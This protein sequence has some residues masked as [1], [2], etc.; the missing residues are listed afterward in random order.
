MNRRKS[1]KKHTSSTYRDWTT[2]T[3]E[4]IINERTK[5]TVSWC[6]CEHTHRAIYKWISKMWDKRATRSK[7]KWATHTPPILSQ[8]VSHQ[9]KSKKIIWQVPLLCTATLCAPFEARLIFHSMS[10]SQATTIVRVSRILTQAD[11][12]VFFSLAQI[13]QYLSFCVHNDFGKGRDRDWMGRM[14]WKLVVCTWIYIRYIV[15]MK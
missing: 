4:Q 10:A 13:S 1:K 8:S 7:S 2:P 3:N 15:L 12:C 9:R 5:E 14:Y 6:G 11:D